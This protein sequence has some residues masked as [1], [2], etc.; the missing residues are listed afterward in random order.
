MLV[1]PGE[2]SWALCGKDGYQN[3][4]N[5]N[6]YMRIAASLTDLTW[7][8]KFDIPK[9]NWKSQKGTYL[10]WALELASLRDKGKSE[11]Q[12]AFINHNHLAKRT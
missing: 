10:Q 7:N 9:T 12:K 11:Q 6:N 2:L 8:V 5:V 4:N 3:A 1:H